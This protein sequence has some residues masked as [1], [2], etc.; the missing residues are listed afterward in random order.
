MRTSQIKGIP[1][2]EPRQKN[3]FRELGVIIKPSYLQMEWLDLGDC[4]IQYDYFTYCKAFFQVLGRRKLC[5]EGDLINLIEALNAVSSRYV[6]ENR[7]KY[8]VKR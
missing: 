5:T 8:L 6:T 2:A 7:L 4:L 3:Q 1:N